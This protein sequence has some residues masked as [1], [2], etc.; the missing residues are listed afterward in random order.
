MI[1]APLYQGIICVSS[2]VHFVFARPSDTRGVS[3]LK[4]DGQQTG[5]T[6]RQASFAVCV[7]CR[8]NQQL[9]AD[10]MTREGGSKYD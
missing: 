4:K 5:R 9:E 1:C 2:A 7:Q 6:S 3:D 10:H 8:R